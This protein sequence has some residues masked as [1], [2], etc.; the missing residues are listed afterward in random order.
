MEIK[1]RNT[2]ANESYSANS[3]CKSSDRIQRTVSTTACRR[4]SGILKIA[5]KL[6]K[7]SVF[8]HKVE[9]SASNLKHYFLCP[10]AKAHKSF[11]NEFC[12]P[13]HNTGTVSEVK[14]F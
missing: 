11:D 6:K 9:A 5:L 10:S 12:P 1:I 8:V 14:Y 4:G 2:S 7:S 3:T 13:P